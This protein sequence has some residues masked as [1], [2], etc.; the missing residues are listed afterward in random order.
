[1]ADITSRKLVKLY[2]EHISDVSSTD[3]P[4]VYP[5]E[6]NSWDLEDF[7]EHLKI[8][9]QYVTD[10]RIEFDLVGVDASIANAFRRILIAEVPTVAIERVYVYN[11]TSVIH[12]EVLSH[13]LGLVPLHINP[14]I[15]DDA[16][17]DYQNNSTDRNTIVFTLDVECTNRPNVKAGET[18]PEKLYINSNVF[19]ESL[20]WVPQG[21]QGSLFAS[22]PPRAVNPKILLAK[23]RPG[24]EIHLEMHA[25][26]STGR[27]HTKFSPVAT[28]TYRLMP[29]I[30]L[31]KPG[32]RYDEPNRRVEKLEMRNQEMAEKFRD[33]FGEGVIEVKKERGK[34][35]VRVKDP[36]RDNVT[37]RILELPEFEDMVKLG[38]VRDWFIFSVE[39][40]GQYPAP[41]LFPV[42][43]SVLR[44]KIRNLKADVERLKREWEGSVDATRLEGER[45]VDMEG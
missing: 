24:Q 41:E 28:A 39:S 20:I 45:D 11:N 31:L 14:R 30:Q 44:G 8:D 21:E 34:Y 2:K 35:F 26:K 18:D 32:D 1:M 3:Y 10:E 36:R 40:V 12:D 15:M 38:R 7:K 17:A 6:D 25:V 23:L 27:D 37:R 33:A 19:A 4:G 43:V 22:D 16:P 9:F 42:S 5:G 13:R 29:H